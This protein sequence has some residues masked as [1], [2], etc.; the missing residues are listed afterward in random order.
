MKGL[1]FFMLITGITVSVIAENEVPIHHF[2]SGNWNLVGSR[3]YQN[4][5]DAKLAKVNVTIPQSG[6]MLY[7]F[8]VK[9]EGGAEDGHGGLGI[10]LF[11]DKAHN[12]ASWGAGRSYLLWVNYDKDPI[13]ELIP[14]GL[15]VQ[16][17]RSISNSRMELLESISLNNYLP[18]LM[19][20]LDRAIPFR[21]IANG[22]TGEVRVYDPTYPR[23]NTYAYFFIDESYLPL[24][25][26]WI[27]L[28]T[29]GLRAS[30]GM[31]LE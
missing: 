28:R 27:A 29:N 10:H 7:D 12:T 26:D 8:N 23:M 13:S 4:D 25:G 19:E 1:V 22:D 24:R 16:V 31:G 3:L 21:I 14:Q 9:Y 17:Y 15:S 6:A 11:V 2:A 30:F 20:N 5:A 18:W